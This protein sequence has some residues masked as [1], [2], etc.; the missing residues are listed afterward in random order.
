MNTRIVPSAI[1]ENRMIEKKS[2]YK[3]EFV[4]LEKERLWPRVWQ[5]SLPGRGDPQDR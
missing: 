5:M 1:A 4:A 2:Y 3:P